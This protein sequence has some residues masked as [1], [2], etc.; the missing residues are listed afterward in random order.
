MKATR[1]AAAAEMIDFFIVK[2]PFC[3]LFCAKGNIAC[4]L[5]LANQN[6]VIFVKNI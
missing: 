5:P 2:I 3:L 4:F 1:A 6:G